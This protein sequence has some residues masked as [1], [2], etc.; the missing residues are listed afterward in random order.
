MVA[1]ASTSSFLPRPIAMPGSSPGSQLYKGPDRGL[2]SPE[3]T[4]TGSIPHLGLK[5]VMI[6]ILPSSCQRN[7]KPVKSLF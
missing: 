6:V 3:L 1:A 4:V 5:S 2:G 7:R